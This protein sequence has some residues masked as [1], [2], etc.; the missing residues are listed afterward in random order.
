MFKYAVV[1]I[2]GKQ[3]DVFPD[4]SLEV[5][6]LG[7]I[8][9][10]ECEKVLLL[11]DMN[12]IS[13]GKPYLKEK[14]SFDVLNNRKVKKIRVATYKAKANTR[15]VKGGVYLT[16]TVKLSLTDHEKKDRTEV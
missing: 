3:Y 11:A 2:A 4:T 5:N 10:F 8:K 13:I 1:E 9:T 6:Y 14:L 12:S 16:S 15:K 7:D